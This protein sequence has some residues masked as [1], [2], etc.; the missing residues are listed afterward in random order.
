MQIARFQD[1]TFRA[2]LV[3]SSCQRARQ[4]RRFFGGFGRQPPQDSGKSKQEH[5]VSLSWTSGQRV[6]AWI[7]ALVPLFLVGCESTEAAT[8]QQISAQRLARP[9]TSLVHDFVVGPEGASTEAERAAGWRF[10]DASAASLV[11]KIR[12]TELPAE[13]AD[14][15]PAATDVQIYGKGSTAELVGYLATTIERARIQ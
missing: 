11:E 5:D 2:A 10:A 8:E 9:D 14:G 7:V 3:R 12:A 1:T 6:A 15:A 4:G 13:R